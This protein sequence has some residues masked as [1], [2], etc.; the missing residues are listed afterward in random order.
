MAEQYDRL[1]IPISLA[2]YFTPFSF[3]FVCLL[4]SSLDF[5]VCL[6]LQFIREYSSK[7]DELVKDKIE[8]QNELKAKESEEKE[9][10]A[11][12]VWTFYSNPFV[13]F[14][15]FLSFSSLLG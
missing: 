10:V 13:S 1:C 5:L 7:V 11:K 8:A 3:S 9:L 12:H 15:S 2:G 14:R 6:T 4:C